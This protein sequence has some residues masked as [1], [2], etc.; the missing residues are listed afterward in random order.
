MLREKVR[1]LR[2]ELTTSFNNLTVF[3]VI[4][5]KGRIDEL[6]KVNSSVLESLIHPLELQLSSYLFIVTMEAKTNKVKGI[7]EEIY[8]ILDKMKN[9]DRS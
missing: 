3:D 2:D 9:V 6:R 4:T 8:A 7:E 5:A 1:L